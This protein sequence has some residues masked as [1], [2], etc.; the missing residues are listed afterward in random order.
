MNQVCPNSWND[1]IRREYHW[2]S[3]TAKI[4]TWRILTVKI[5]KGIFLYYLY[6]F[7]YKSSYYICIRIEIFII[8]ISFI[9]TFFATFR[10][11]IIIW[12]WVRQIVILCKICIWKR[13]GTRFTLII[14]WPSHL[15]ITLIY[16]FTFKQ[17]F[18][19]FQKL[20]TYF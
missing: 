14:F 18:F 11:F 20:Q 6:S 10:K 15:D 7:Q 5:L 19:L 2:K 3:S 1:L 13:F 4:L 12:I 9:T 17:D 8:F 16:F